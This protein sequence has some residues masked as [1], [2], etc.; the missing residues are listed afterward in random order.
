M[1]GE[2]GR[3]MP[4]CRTPDADLPAPGWYA[5]LAGMPQG[6]CWTIGE[7]LVYLGSD[8]CSAARS[9]ARLEEADGP[10]AKQP[11]K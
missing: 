10:T 1:M 7:R 11:D 4:Y 8:I 9:I 2:L 5:T 6:R 3:V